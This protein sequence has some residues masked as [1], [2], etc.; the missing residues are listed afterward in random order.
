MKARKLP[1]DLWYVRVLRP[2]AVMELYHFNMRVCEDARLPY[3][4]LRMLGGQDDWCLPWLDRSVDLMRSRY[5][6][7][8]RNLDDSGAVLPLRLASVDRI[9]GSLQHTADNLRLLAVGLNLACGHTD[10]DHS[11]GGWLDGL[12]QKWP[13]RQR[14]WGG[15]VPG[16]NDWEEDVDLEAIIDADEQQIASEA[17][18]S[19][20]ALLA[21]MEAE[22]DD[23]AEAGDQDGSQA[24]SDDSGSHDDGAGTPSP[25]HQRSARAE[26]HAHP[27]QQPPPRR[28]APLPTH[29]IFQAETCATRG[30]GHCAR[31]AFATELGHNAFEL[32]DNVLVRRSAKAGSLPWPT[33]EG[34]DRVLRRLWPERVMPAPGSIR[35]RE[36]DD[37]RFEEAQ[38]FDAIILAIAAEVYRR[39]IA[40][41]NTSST[42]VAATLRNAKL[43]YGSVKL[44][45]ATR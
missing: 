6:G 29:G 34:R 23:E 27:P 13:E 15:T 2:Q 17:G 7:H 41:D 35:W 8:G 24:G 20:E 36:L 22:T 12:K 10:N 44:L 14:Q 42:T 43:L 1:G 33:A 3:S 39:R 40:V 32:F 4:H 11:I 21:S 37:K 25:R 45:L 16:A 28:Q 38:W 30:Y 19:L 18:D 9:D 31:D 26:Q 5:V